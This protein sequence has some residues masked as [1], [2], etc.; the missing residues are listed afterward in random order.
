M[1]RT[2]D[3]LGGFALDVLPPLQEH[4]DGR[5]GSTVSVGYDPRT[6]HL[7]E[8]QRLSATLTVDGFFPPLSAEVTDPAHPAERTVF[9]DYDTD[10]LTL[11]ANNKLTVIDHTPLVESNT[12]Q[13]P[14]S[15]VAPDPA[16]PH[17][18]VVGLVFDES[19]KVNDDGQL[20][21]N[22]ETVSKG[23][24]AISVRNLENFTNLTPEDLLDLFGGASDLLDD[25]PDD[26]NGAIVS[27]Q[28]SSD[29]SQIGGKLHI[30][31]QGLDRIP[32]FQ[33]ENGITSDA[34]LTYNSTLSQLRAPNVRVTTKFTFSDDAEVPSKAFVAQ[35]IQAQTDGAVDVSAE[36]NGR[37]TLAVRKDATLQVDSSNN[38]GV[39]V[40]PLVD[41]STV[42][43]VNN[44]IATGLVFQSAGGLKLT[45]GNLVGLNPTVNAPI[46]FDGTNTLG[47]DVS[48]LA[49]T[50]LT[51]SA[52]KLAVQLSGST[53]VTV[54][55]ATLSLDL[56]GSN[57]IS[58]SGNVIRYTANDAPDEG[59][60]EGSPG[61]GGEGSPATSGAA[62]AAGAAAAAATGAVAGTAAG[63]AAAGLVAAAGAAESAVAAGSATAAAAIG[64]VFGAI[65]GVF[66]GMIADIF[67][68]GGNDEGSGSTVVISTEP[69]PLRGTIDPHAVSPFPEGAGT[70]V[71]A[72]KWAQVWTSTG[73]TYIQPL[74]NANGQAILDLGY[75]YGYKPAV[76]ANGQPK[77]VRG[78]I[79]AV[80]VDPITKQVR[81]LFD[82]PRGVTTDLN[83]V[84]DWQAVNF[85]YMRRYWTLKSAGYQPKHAA[86][87]ALSDAVGPHLASLSVGAAATALPTVVTGSNPALMQLQGPQ[88]LDGSTHLL[89][90][91][92]A[93]AYGRTGI[94]LTGRL[95]DA[96][97]FWS[98]AQGR[99]ALLFNTNAA[100]TSGTAVGAIGTTRFALQ[101]NMQTQ[102]LGIL[103]ANFATNAPA[104]AVG[105]NGTV[106]AYATADAS[107][108]GS[109]AW[110]V[111]GGASVAK[112][113]YV[114]SSLVTTGTASA[115]TPTQSGHLATK[116]YVDALAA[117]TEFAVRNPSSATGAYALLLLVNDQT[118]SSF[119][120][121]LNSSTRT[122]DGG[123]NCTTLRNDTGGDLR[124]QCKTGGGA[125]GLRI[126]QAGGYEF[127]NLGGAETA[128]IDADGSLHVSAVAAAT[129]TFSGE[130]TS[131][132]TSSSSADDVLTTKQ[133]VD[134]KVA[135]VTPGSGDPDATVTQVYVDSADALMQAQ[136][137]GVKTRAT[138]LETRATALETTVSAAS[139]GL[140]DR[141][142]EAETT[143]TA[144]QLAVTGKQASDANL[145]HL[146]G[147]TPYMDKTLTV[148]FPGVGG[149]SGTLFKGAS[150]V[151]AGNYSLSLEAY[152]VGSGVV[153]YRWNMKNNGTYDAFMTFD[154]GNVGFSGNVV[155]P[156]PTAS[157]QVATKAYVDAAIATGTT[158]LG[159]KADVTYVDEADA[160]LA[161]QIIAHTSE[162]ATKAATTYV[163][164][165]D[166]AL[167]T[168]ATA[169]ETTV[170]AASTGLVD[171]VG[172][173]ETALTATQLA[174]T[175]K[176]ASDA[177]LTHLSG[178]TPYVDK[179][180][181]MYFPGV[182][183]YGG[184]LFTSASPVEP[185]NYNLSLEAYTVASG[186]IGYRWNMKNNGTYDA[187]MTFDRGNVAFS[188]NV[189]AP[190]P[191]ASNQ[192]A[193]KAYVDAAVPPGYATTD[194]VD[195]A[196]S[197]KQASDANLT[198]LSGA[199]PYIDKT[200]G[201]NVTGTASTRALNLYQPSIANGSNVCMSLGRANATY[202]EAQFTFNKVTNNNNSNYLKMQLNG[203]TKGLWIRGDG[204]AGA[205]GDFNAYGNVTLAGSGILTAPGG[206][207][208]GAV[209]GTT[210]TAAAHLATKSYV[211]TKQPLHSQ[212]TSLSS[213]TPYL[214]NPVTG[215]D[216]TDGAHLTTKSYVD[217]R[218]SN[219]AL[220][221]VYRFTGTDLQY[222]TSAYRYIRWSNV[223]FPKT[224]TAVFEI[225]AQLFGDNSGYAAYVS[226][227]GTKVP[228]SDTTYHFNN[229]MWREVTWMGTAG[230]FAGVG[231]NVVDL[232]WQTGA[233]CSDADV[234]HS[235]AVWSA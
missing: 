188:G 197:G 225:T 75:P 50:G 219:M 82:T 104:L 29:F 78:D 207:F 231:S 80:T 171:R 167:G 26:Y 215:V 110:Q 109:G 99:N 57:G 15:A 84:S 181:T 71:W 8:H 223:T 122:A 105:E 162:L 133:Y 17:T 209:S 214:S 48:A 92:G 151:E 11:D 191:T 172:A 47:L 149:Y 222:T 44:K 74:L 25:V 185:G 90:T 128:R 150:P 232:I 76:D 68:G 170:N 81:V 63:A 210:P 178:A 142:A 194:Y 235:L 70:D 186:V 103:A 177:N 146:S 87:D 27:L 160:A 100:T 94:V 143:L 168:R 118:S 55:G 35:Y 106:V 159:G 42:R 19:L 83:L 201:V 182:G 129:G 6:M 121:F 137:D 39:N 2:T 37:R 41:G 155:A 21:V 56:Q 14:L 189:V 165:Q 163:D 156:S 67:S 33:L 13:A 164:Q 125:W 36:T 198:H 93:N 227:N 108:T 176:Q 16:Q 120:M 115:A 141:M 62:S 140:V 58:V 211:D 96:N 116:G 43:I 228:G 79:A 101:H 190:S 230:V 112:N 66:G 173:A 34:S 203:Q 147:A 196:V 40:G 127:Q 221:S 49:G 1:S 24:G 208:S 157:N 31:S 205:D 136:V 161:G 113:L 18:R 22:K 4:E 85:D 192:V 204:V 38:L 139:T 23:A 132:Q 89:V 195:T 28:T 217:T 46:T 12:Y 119:S 154:R 126:K 86:L 91:N 72:A 123:A 202:D 216:P 102:E 212:L 124:L 98:L 111:K 158:G 73:G 175:G 153:G 145:T 183:G 88:T 220:P 179:T 199:T 224:G 51:T 5:G 184:T 187:F 180:L 97:D 152:G 226:I 61:G 10:T 77:I 52:G 138:A 218:V 233:G 148:Y 65:A 213:T 45:N 32:L 200:L 59:G 130:I 69:G 30:A 134:L 131:A 60:D 7:D 166:T 234:T 144:T 107:S 20:L 193:T 174:V 95:Q 169:L 135:A 53:G 64:G 114:G 117:G 3:G 9:L 229:G 206:N 54:N